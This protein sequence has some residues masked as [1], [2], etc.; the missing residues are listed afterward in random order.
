MRRFLEG[1]YLTLASLFFSA[2]ALCFACRLL[3][4]SW[5][6]CI[7][8][9]LFVVPALL[10]YIPLMYCGFPYFD[11]I[12]WECKTLGLDFSGFTY[13]GYAAVILMHWVPGVFFLMLFLRC[14]RRWRESAG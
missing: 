12:D 11:F 7:M 8:T 6:R 13:H 4:E 9:F 14:R 5:A 3:P 2:S 1:A 10:I